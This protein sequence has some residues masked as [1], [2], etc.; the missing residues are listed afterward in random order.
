MPPDGRVIR[1]AVPS[2]VGPPDQELGSVVPQPRSVQGAPEVRPVVRRQDSQLVSEL[3]RPAELEEMLSLGE[4]EAVV[5][6]VRVPSGKGA[7]RVPDV[8]VARR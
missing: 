6:V 1:P 5:E 7:R 8:E 3:K 4:R 2:R